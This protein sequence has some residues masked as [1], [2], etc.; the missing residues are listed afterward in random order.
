MQNASTVDLL[1]NLAR[2]LF[3]IA[4]LWISYRA[5]SRA[6]RCP[7]CNRTCLKAASFCTGCGFQ[8]KESAERL[9]APTDA[10]GIFRRVYRVLFI[11]FG[12]FIALLG[13]PFLTGFPA[14]MLAWL[15]GSYAVLGAGFVL[16]F[17]VRVSR[18]AACNQFVQLGEDK[19]FSTVYCACCGNLVNEKVAH[20]ANW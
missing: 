9:S 16:Y 13:V 14:G 11:Y 2:F 4:L 8:L 20:S 3:P 6:P 7:Q 18:C 15:A 12:G 17:Y 1:L 19:A 10:V 5:R